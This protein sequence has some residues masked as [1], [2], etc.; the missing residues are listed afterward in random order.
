MPSYA[1]RRIFKIRA[2]GRGEKINLTLYDKDNSLLSRKGV[3]S[4]G[5]AYFL[6]GCYSAMPEAVFD[7]TYGTEIDGIA[8]E[9]K[10]LRI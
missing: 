3:F 4:K 7:F 2:D 10:E 8:V 9:Y 6:C 5:R 1:K